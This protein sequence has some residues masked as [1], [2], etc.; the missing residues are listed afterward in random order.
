[1]RVLAVA[2]AVG[3][4]WLIISA[5]LLTENL[6][7][8]LFLWT[9]WAIVSAAEEPGWWPQVRALALIAALTLCRLNLAVMFVVLVV[10]VVVGEIMSRRSGPEGRFRMRE[11]L[12][13]RAPTVAATALGLLAVAVIARDGG[14]RLGA[15]GGFASTSFFDAVWGST[16]DD[17]GRA[18]LTNLRSLAVG[19][20]VFPLVLGLA[21]TLAGARGRL[22]ARFV[23]PAITTLASFVAVLAVVSIWTGLT[24]FEERYVFYVYAPV[25]IVAVALVRQLTRAAVDIAVAGAVVL[26]AMAEG[27]VHP[28]NIGVNF[29]SAPGG[30]FWTRVVDHR[31]RSLENDVLGMLPGAGGGWELFAIGVAALVVVALLSARRAW[32]RTAVAVG[33]GV[34]AVGQVLV[35]Q[36]DY[37]KLLYGTS[38][39]PGGLALSDD[40]S[41]DRDEWIDDALPDGAR[42][43]IVPALASPQAP[44]GD[45]ERQQFWNKSLDASV[46]IK[47]AFV[48]TSVPPGFETINAGLQD[49]IATWEGTSYDWVVAQPNDPRVQFS[50][51]EVARSDTAPLALYKLDLPATAV[52]TGAGVD[53][54][55]AMLAGSEALLT[56]NRRA[57]EDVRAVTLGLRAPAELPGD[58]RWTIRRSGGGR[59]ASGTLAPGAERSVRLDVPR[60]RGECAN[61]V[62]RLRTA[63]AIAQLQPPFLGAPPPPRPVR[64]FLTHAILAR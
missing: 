55:G 12:R 40:R 15:Y 44:Y 52:W 10:A 51:T 25:A 47:F 53:S 23:I 49:G 21:A 38:Q 4:P 37:D 11:A 17:S 63:G 9:V 30:A 46:A 34:C 58:V 42:A 19:S 41:L 7:F 29:F 48:P 45:T 28:G 35:L 13:R 20:L 14:S 1:M 2:L 27:I 3:V 50:G 59:V 61:D 6:A 5:H 26:L 24:V 56:L 22:G 8:P 57:G 18:M 64:L 36:Y 62:W 43:A 33:L 31:V 39:A 60:C 16:A 32:L 54:D